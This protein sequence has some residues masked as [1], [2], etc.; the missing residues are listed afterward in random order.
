MTRARRRT[1]LGISVLGASIHV[2]LR[3][4]VPEPQS[5][6]VAEGAVRD[7]LDGIPWSEKSSREHTELCHDRI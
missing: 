1:Q 2:P 4:P 5:G 3:L 6:H 7:S